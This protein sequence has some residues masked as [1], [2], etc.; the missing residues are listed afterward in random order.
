MI[1]VAC[2]NDLKHFLLNYKSKIRAR[3]R[4][5]LHRLISEQTLQLADLNYERPV[6]RRWHDVFA[7][8]CSSQRTLRL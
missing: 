7:S 2:N 3:T 8:T 4:F 6:L 5:L 1:A